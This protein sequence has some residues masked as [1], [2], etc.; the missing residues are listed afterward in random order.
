MCFSFNDA[1]NRRD[2]ERD[3]AGYCRRYG[4]DAAQLDAVML[5]ARRLA[6]RPR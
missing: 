3:E 1:A 6:R 4:L 2:F 5:N